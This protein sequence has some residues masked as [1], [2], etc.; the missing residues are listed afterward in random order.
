MEAP[1]TSAAG[2]N[3]RDRASIL[4][5]GVV[6]IAI[7]TLAIAAAAF[8]VGVS[9]PS[10]KATS[11]ALLSGIEARGVHEAAAFGDK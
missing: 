2:N 6:A 5:D 7:I 3:P 11:S 1:K 4:V 10:V 8:A 9:F